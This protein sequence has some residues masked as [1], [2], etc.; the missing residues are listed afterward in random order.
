MYKVL[1]VDHGPWNL[2][3]SGRIFHWNEKGFEMIALMESPKDVAEILNDK[4]DAALPGTFMPMPSR[5][6]FMDC[7]QIA[8][9]YENLRLLCE[10]LYQLY[11]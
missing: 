9:Q 8:G 5:F 4:L 10:H 2:S 7:N 11:G 6:E 3:R 1:I